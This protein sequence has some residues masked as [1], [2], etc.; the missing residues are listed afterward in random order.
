MQLQATHYYVS[1]PLH[2]LLK[3]VTRAVETT[4]GPM[5]QAP[6]AKHLFQI[7]PGRLVIG[8]PPGNELAKT[9]LW[10]WPCRRWR[11]GANCGPGPAGGALPNGGNGP[12]GAWAAQWFNVANCRRWRPRKA[13]HLLLNTNRS[14]TVVKASHAAHAHASVAPEAASASVAPQERRPPEAAAVSTASVAPEARPAAP[15]AAR[16]ARLRRQGAARG[17]AARQRWSEAARCVA[18]RS[19]RTK[20]KRQS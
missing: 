19:E 13:Q 18:Q 4:H 11:P 5:E 20:A 9:L 15:V 2:P 8:H 3:P 12:A 1:H 14:A 7:Y 10:P 17:I 6:P 16:R